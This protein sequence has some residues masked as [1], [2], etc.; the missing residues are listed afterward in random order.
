MVFSFAGSIANFIDDDW[1]LIER[2]LDFRH[3]ADFE[4]QGVHAAKAFVDSA[5]K[6]GSLDKMSTIAISD[7]DVIA[8]LTCVP[9]TS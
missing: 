1:E 3:L 8:R 6:C 9:I 5:S 7:S 2:L 4:H